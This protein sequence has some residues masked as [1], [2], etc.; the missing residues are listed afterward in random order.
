ML[1]A[2]KCLSVSGKGSE[3]GRRGG[4]KGGDPVDSSRLMVKD[5]L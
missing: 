3:R 5:L 1:Y 4:R 2:L